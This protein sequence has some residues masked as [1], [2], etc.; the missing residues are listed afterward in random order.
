MDSSKV[1]DPVRLG[2]EVTVPEGLMRIVEQGLLD[3]TPWHIMR[4][5]DVVERLGGLRERYSTKYVPFARRQD[6]DDLACMDAAHPGKVVIVHDFA[7]EGFELRETYEAFWDW[8]RIAIEEM[9][10]FDP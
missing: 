8:F 5:E 9:I 7:S 3:L 6:N 10:A 2:V 1:F 4:T